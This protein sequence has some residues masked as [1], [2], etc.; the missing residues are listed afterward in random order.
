MAG[1]K[2][3]LL[4]YA[5][6]EKKLENLAAI[7]VNL[8]NEFEASALAVA[9]KDCLDFVEYLVPAL[10]NADVP[11]CT[12]AGSSALLHVPKGTVRSEAFFWKRTNVDVNLENKYGF[13][14]LKMLECE[15]D[16]LKESE[17]IMEQLRI[18]KELL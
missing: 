6:E 4:H 16:P 10:V 7:D 17:E 2:K 5:Y 12:K 13:S 8:L 1:R 9:S 15:T 3:A 11:S 18:T 14:A